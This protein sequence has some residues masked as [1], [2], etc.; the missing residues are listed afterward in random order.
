MT[1]F[2]NTNVR[3]DDLPQSEPP[4]QTTI[5]ATDDELVDRQQRA[6]LIDSKIQLFGRMVNW[7]LGIVCVL[8]GLLVAIVSTYLHMLCKQLNIPSD[9]WHI[10]L[11]VALMAS[12]ILS[13]TLTLSSRFGDTH[14]KSTQHDANEPSTLAN[15]PAWQEFVTAIKDL[16]KEI[17]N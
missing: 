8:I 4:A 9:F 11:L 14:N 1:D 15:I 6:K 12:T 3:I 7:T 16:V 17:R 5:E 2:G 13:I 10:P